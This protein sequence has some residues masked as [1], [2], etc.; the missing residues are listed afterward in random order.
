MKKVIL[1]TIFTFL[2]FLLIYTP[3]DVHGLGTPF[4]GRITMMRYC[5]C[6][7]SYLLTVGPPKGGSF[8]YSP[9]SYSYA[10]GPPSHV[11]Q[12]LLG[13]AGPTMLCINP[14]CDGACC[15]NGAGQSI[16]YHGSS[17]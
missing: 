11:G 6:N 5:L 16:L 12:W 13:M 9:V 3:L 1:K 8:M 15:P 7:A 17:M 10:Y 4:G 2:L 14:V